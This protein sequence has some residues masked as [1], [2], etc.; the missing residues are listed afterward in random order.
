MVRAMA[1]ARDLSPLTDADGSILAS[2]GWHRYLGSE[3]IRRMHLP[4]T[5]RGRGSAV[6]KHL[7]RLEA[8]GLITGRKLVRSG[9]KVWSATVAGL[10]VLEG[11]GRLPFAPSMKGLRLAR[12]TWV[13]NEVGI[14][15]LESARQRGDEFGVHGW[16]HEVPLRRNR[17]IADAL[18]RYTVVGGGRPGFATA[19]LEVDRATYNEGRIGEKLRQYALV[20]EEENLWR[21]RFPRGFPFVLFVVNAADERTEDASADRA[22]R[23]MAYWRKASVGLPFRITTLGQL[24]DAGP[25]GRIWSDPRDPAVKLDW[26]GQG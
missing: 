18:I 12:H 19:L 21:E 6:S 25:F 20:R 2:I 23:I 11:Q 14:S 3:Q 24:R 17:V 7:A 22:E 16:D 4:T 5:K 10:D 1:P 8:R 26:L 9:E 13:V 15:L